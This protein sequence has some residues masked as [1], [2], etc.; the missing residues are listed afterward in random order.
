MNSLDSGQWNV[1]ER[2]ASGAPLHEVLEAVVLLVEGESANMLCSILLFD[3]EHQTL[4]HGAAPNLPRDY[5]A[6]IDGSKI[7]PDAG[8]CGAA[9]VRRQGGGIEETST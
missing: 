1:L 6:A 9:A 4:R 3:V 2:V 8:S 7:G 5:V